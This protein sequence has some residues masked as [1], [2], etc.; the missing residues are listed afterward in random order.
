MLEQALGKKAEEKATWEEW[1][2]ASKSRLPAFQS[3]INAIDVEGASV[4][5]FIQERQ[6]KL[7]P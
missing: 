7:K 1:I 5:T 6:K 2:S 3:L 4:I